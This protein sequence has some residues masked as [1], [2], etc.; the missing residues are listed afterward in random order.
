MRDI[1][2]S[3][4]RRQALIKSIE[5][6]MKICDYIAAIIGTSG[7]LIMAPEV[8]IHEFNSLVTTLRAHTITNIFQRNYKTPM[9]A[10]KPPIT[11]LNC[12]N[13]TW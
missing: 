2:L 7:I 3:D 10:S 12:A 6:R 5:T 1:F 11:T 4:K 8:Y 13:S 9:I